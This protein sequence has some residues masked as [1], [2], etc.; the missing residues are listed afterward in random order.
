MKPTQFLIFRK[1]ILLP[2]LL[3]I[4]LFSAG[5]GENKQERDGNTGT[6]SGS[7]K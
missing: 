6:L 1:G 5:C 7:G 2:I 4:M 3:L